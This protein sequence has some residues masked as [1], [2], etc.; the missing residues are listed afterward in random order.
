MRAPPENTAWRMAAT[1]RV[2]ALRPTACSKCAASACSASWCKSIL[3]PEMCCQ[4]ELTDYVVNVSTHLHLSTVV[5]R[6]SKLAFQGLLG[7]KKTQAEACVWEVQ[8]KRSDL[9][10]LRLSLK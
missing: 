7:E 10:R 4:L 6:V 5:F 9:Q 1:S 2:G 8:I 3:P